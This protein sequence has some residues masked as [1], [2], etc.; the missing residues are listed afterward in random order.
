MQSVFYIAA[1][2]ICMQL[3]QKTHNWTHTLGRLAGPAEVNVSISFSFFLFLLFFLYVRWSSSSCPPGCWDDSLNGCA[4]GKKNIYTFYFVLFLPRPS[5]LLARWNFNFNFFQAVDLF[6]SFW[7]LKLI[8]DGCHLIVFFWPVWFPSGHST[9]VRRHLQRRQMSS[10]LWTCP[11]R[12]AAK[13]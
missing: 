6:Q 10:A 11:T 8:K 5:V 1:D 12:P 9:P 13:L 4:T 2:T 7:R 3:E